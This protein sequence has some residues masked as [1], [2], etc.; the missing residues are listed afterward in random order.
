[1]P[2]SPLSARQSTEAQVSTLHPHEPAIPPALDDEGRCLV[3][4]LTMELNDAEAERDRYHE[5]LVG[6]VAAATTGVF[7]DKA[8]E[9][10][11]ALL[12]AEDDE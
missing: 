10:A 11:A 9:D 5:A 6:M 7:L 1:M 2:E 4:R 8:L 12:F 3:C